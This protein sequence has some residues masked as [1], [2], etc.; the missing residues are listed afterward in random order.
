MAGIAELI[1]LLPQL[2]SFSQYAFWV[3]TVLFFGSLAVR[4]ATTLT[5]WYLRWPLRVLTGALALVGAYSFAP[6]FPVDGLF[7]L[8]QVNVLGAGVAVS[9]ALAAGLYLLTKN[10]DTSARIERKMEKLERQLKKSGRGGKTPEA[11]IG[12]VLIVFIVVVSLA[13]FRG[14]PNPIAGFLSSAL[15][16]GGD[17]NAGPDMMKYCTVEGE[18]FSCKIPLTVAAG[19]LGFK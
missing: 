4:G 3:F 19:G 9:L 16:G 14:A 1:A 5:D 17:E 13:F 18:F 7:Q 12:V 8:I 6:F 10:M 2:V 15:A 11:V